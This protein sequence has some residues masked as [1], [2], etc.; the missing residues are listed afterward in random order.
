MEIDGA[1]L[2]HLNFKRLGA[3]IGLGK[4]FDGEFTAVLNGGG[5]RRIRVIKVK[6]K[7]GVVFVGAVRA[8]EDFA[9]EEDDGV[10]SGAELADDLELRGREVSG[11]AWGRGRVDDGDGLA[12]ELDAFADEVAFAEDVLDV[13]GGAEVEVEASGGAEEA[14]E[15]D[16]DLPERSWRATA[17][18]RHTGSWRGSG[19]ELGG[20]ERRERGGG[21]G[22]LGGEVAHGEPGD[23]V[24]HGGRLGTDVEGKCEQQEEDSRAPSHSGEKERTRNDGCNR[25]QTRCT[26]V[27]LDARLDRWDCGGREEEEEGEGCGKGE[28]G[29]E[30]RRQR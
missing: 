4:T 22:A 18:F 11:V 29:N 21:D 1:N 8:V 15:A 17:G 14:G 19:A 28:K 13:E 9:D 24:R 10:A 27:E 16:G 6:I 3:Q 12:V 23:A 20:L 30:G 5:G 2:E 26:A 7:W 25:H